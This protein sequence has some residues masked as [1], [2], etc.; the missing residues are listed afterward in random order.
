MSRSVLGFELYIFG[1]FG[2]SYNWDFLSEFSMEHS[3]RAVLCNN[4]QKICEIMQQCSL[5]ILFCN[6]L[7]RD[8]M[9]SYFG[10]V[11]FFGRS[12]LGYFITLT[13][14]GYSVGRLFN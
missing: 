3:Y 8:P 11:Q 1:C 14:V 13:T 10:Y 6:V 4:L 12:V 9:F 5:R 2:Y 7:I